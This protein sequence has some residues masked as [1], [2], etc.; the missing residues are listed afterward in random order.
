MVKY[1]AI[2]CNRSHHAGDV[3]TSKLDFRWNQGNN[4]RIK[5]KNWFVD[6]GI[7]DVV[8][9]LWSKLTVEKPIFA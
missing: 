3:S 7:S 5:S 2:G 8:I 1:G 9:H 6:V 4:R